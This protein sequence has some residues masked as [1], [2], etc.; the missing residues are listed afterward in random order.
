[1]ARPQHV[2]PRHHGEVILTPDQR[3]RV[4]VSSTLGEL[5]DERRAVRRAI[6]DLHLVPVMFELG[7][8]VHPPRSLY[9]SYLEQSHVFIGIYWQRYGWVAPDMEI[10]GLEDEYLLSGDKPR[11]IYVKRPA[12][13]QEPRLEEL[14][15]RIEQQGELSYKSFATPEELARLVADDL[16]VLLSEAYQQTVSSMDASTTE[17]PAR[18]LTPLPAEPN[19]F[20]GRSRELAE[21]ASL[22]E[23]DTVRAITLVGP[24]GIGKTRIALQ[25]AARSSSQVA[26]V[27]LANLRD[28][29]EVPTAVATAVGLR[30]AIHDA[31]SL[32]DHLSGAPLL[33]LLDNIE[34]VIEACGWVAELLEAAP[35]VRVLVTSREPMRISGEHEIVVA[36][37]TMEDAVD[38]FGV[39]ASAAGGIAALD[40][41]DAIEAI[42]ARLDG[43]P[44]AIELAASRARVLPPQ[45]L[46]ARLND[47][48]GFLR[49]G[50]RD[51]PE[52][53]R[54]LRSTLDWSHDLLDDCERSAFA[55]IGAFSAS[56]SLEAAEV[57]IDAADCGDPLEMLASLVDRS[58]VR[59]EPT[60]EGARFRLLSVIGEYAREK[61][62][63]AAFADT[64]RNAHATFFRDL[65]LRCQGPLRCAQQRATIRLLDEEA[66]NIRSAV[67]WLLKARRHGDAAKIAWAIWPYVWA[68]TYFTEVRALAE[69]TLE[70][71][72]NPADRARLL[73]VAADCSFWQGDAATALPLLAE[74]EAI[75]EQLADDEIIG[76]AKLSRGLGM[77]FYTTAEEARATLG[78]ALVR[79][80]RRGNAWEE[81]IT[82]TAI[83][84]LDAFSDQH[85]STLDDYEHA[86]ALGGALNDDFVMAMAE[87]NLADYLHRNGDRER[88]VEVLASALER[89][90]V[91]HAPYPS[92]NFLDLVAYFAV[93]V[94][95]FEEAASLMGAA[96]SLR[97][98]MDVPLWQAMVPRRN[99][100]LHLVRTALG[101]D[102]QRFYD[103]GRG[104]RLAPALEMAAEVVAGFRT[105]SALS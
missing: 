27:P 53:Q 100:T 47:A 1:M 57:V 86:V 15:G 13:A 36:P 46:L 61:L 38:L 63:G 58:L 25:A 9:R 18:A 29:S 45:A 92:T 79:F 17:R 97:T 12:P 50:S 56:F 69:I 76:G 19:R 90:R 74:A 102:F 11:L 65:T 51:A 35:G 64:I 34:H 42:C 22:L 89:Y 23:D 24:G 16:A 73:I 101:G 6:E 60:A 48:L 32:A 54:A 4:F 41:A 87:T 43:I 52:R 80:R 20:V 44:L 95:H 82:A 85:K 26:F 30:D 70:G 104:V 31:S 10:S 72:I 2:A 8:S 98:E 88:A 21:V 28:H 66:L 84:W 33:L 39:R 68:R 78:D 83:C 3:V 37:M 93:G 59:V 105:V 5:A 62:D 94:D 49:G 40:A 75:G 96:D 71:E 55:A 81:A 7:A 99:A 14:L 91:M 103:S 77:P 67:E